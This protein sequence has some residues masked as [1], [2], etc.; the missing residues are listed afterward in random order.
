M[1]QKLRTPV[2]GRLGENARI[3][4][5]ARRLLVRR[6]R[7]LAS[8][9]F[10]F[11]MGTFT[12]C[13]QHRCALST[14]RSSTCTTSRYPKL[15]DV[16]ALE[17]ISSERTYAPRTARSAVRSERYQQ[18]NAHDTTDVWR[19]RLGCLQ[20]PVRVCRTLRDV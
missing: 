5:C 12:P 15:Q 19:G 4:G 14:Q 8:E 6:H 11:A 2:L 1:D 3:S 20:E 18:H 13:L 9:K 7:A 17:L 16:V 10:S